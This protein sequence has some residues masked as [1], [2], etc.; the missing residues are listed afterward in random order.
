MKKKL[1]IK[2]TPEQQTIREL[3]ERIVKAQKPVRILDAIKWDQH[4]TAEFF[5]KKGKEL[6][7]VNKDYYARHP[8]PYDPENKMLEF[9]DIERDIK[10]VLGDYSGVGGIMTRMCRE[11][12]ETI[13]MLE[14]R[15]TR[16]FGKISQELYGSSN[17]VFYAGA[18][19]IYDLANT[20]T[21][22][23]H[24]LIDEVRSERD[25]KKHHAK[26]AISILQYALNQYFNDPNE[27]VRVELSD[28]IIADAAAGAET[29]KI[30]R[31]AKFSDRD[32][33]Y[34]EIHE[35]WVHI[36]TTM[37]GL[38]QP[39]CTF[40]SK[41]PP[42]STITQEGLGMIMEVFTF[43]SFPSRIQRINNRINA[44][45]MAEEGADF[46]E[47]YRFYLEHGLEKRDAYVSAS[48]VFRGS[49]PNGLPFTKDLAYS[50]GFIAIYNYIRLV[51]REGLVQRIPLLFLGKTSLEDIHIY[52]DLLE[53]NI[54]VP[55]KYIPPQF[56]DLAALS[57][58]MCYSLFLNKINLTRLSQD[59][60]EIL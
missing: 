11:Y 55:P 17:E 19:T 14:S 51:I 12:R 50:K 36:G 13:R 35:G 39:I 42:S 15:G 1:S 45:H 34:L 24:N 46:L 9:Y 32:L 8:L 5:K 7:A 26:K 38:L 3:S 25:E 4:I 57:S 40:L 18:P 10:R 48:R 21:D 52:A 22:I 33:R 23:L 49:T 30:R 20:L 41:G 31:D 16:Q 54:I 44:I 59:Y 6:P 37:N 27:Q 60:K 43:T 29:I 47:I 56:K 28:G 58:W 2:L 53:Q